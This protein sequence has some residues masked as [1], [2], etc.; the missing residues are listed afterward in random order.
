MLGP[1]GSE[2]FHYFGQL[3]IIDIEANLVAAGAGAVNSAIGTR[4][5][6]VDFATEPV[7]E[8]WNLFLDNR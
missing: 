5:Q 7:H 4:G 2:I 3:G 1:D 8:D 6:W